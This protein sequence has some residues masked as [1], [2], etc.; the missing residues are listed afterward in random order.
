MNCDPVQVYTI[1]SHPSSI[2]QQ[3]WRKREEHG[4]YVT[5][6]MFLE[7]ARDDEEGGVLRKQKPRRRLK[8]APGRYSSVVWG[9]RDQPQIWV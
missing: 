9:K 2:L 7:V 8:S 3:P 6:C 4:L 1:I 5:E